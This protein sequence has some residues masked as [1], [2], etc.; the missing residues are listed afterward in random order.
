MFCS[1]R[2]KSV[3]FQR[4]WHA[5]Q[6]FYSKYTWI[7]SRITAPWYDHQHVAQCVL[8]TALTVF[9][10]WLCFCHGPL[11]A[12]VSVR[13]AH[14]SP[15]LFV[16][17][18]TIA[19]ATAI[20]PGLRDSVPETTGLTRSRD[21]FQCTFRCT[22]YICLHFHGDSFFFYYHFHVITTVLH[23]WPPW[24]VFDVGV[25]RVIPA[26]ETSA[27]GALPASI[28]LKSRRVLLTCPSWQNMW[29]NS[30]PSDVLQVKG[31]EA[32]TWTPAGSVCLPFCGTY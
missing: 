18:T 31:A 2:Q 26:E 14:L 16:W 20:T 22:L 11:R 17:C 12:G 10:L 27:V 30:L 1:A 13:A 3:L 21:V 32:V 4:S 29:E 23:Q 5:L 19:I 25:C 28:S 7:N 9:L 15:A 6:S 8:T 24:H